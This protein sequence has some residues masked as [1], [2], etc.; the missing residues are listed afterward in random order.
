MRVDPRA[1]IMALELRAEPHHEGR[2]ATDAVLVAICTAQCAG[3]ERVAKQVERYWGKPMECLRS[4]TGTDG[5]VSS[6]PVGDECRGIPH[7]YVARARLRQA[8]S[9]F[10]STPPSVPRCLR[11]INKAC[12]TSTRLNS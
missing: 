1:D 3:G 7:G 2:L 6:R 12:Q 8:H 11:A 10:G 5:V 4:V 9:V